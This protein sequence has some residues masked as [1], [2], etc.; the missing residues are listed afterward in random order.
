[1]NTPH[2]PTAKQPTKEEMRNL[3]ETIEEAIHT[4]QLKM[5]H[6]IA[7]QQAYKKTSTYVYHYLLN[8]GM[9]Q[10]YNQK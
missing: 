5:A 7:E 8:T 3:E 2:Q 10:Y 6:F 1:M 9:S 4:R